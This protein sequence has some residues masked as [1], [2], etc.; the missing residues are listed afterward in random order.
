M[1]TIAASSSPIIDR[2]REIDRLDRLADLLDGRWRIP[3]IGVRFGID[4]VIGLIPGIG[5]TL[6]LAVSGWLVWRAHLLGVRSS[7]ILRMVANVGIDWLAGSVPLIG[8]LF[9]VAWK[10]N[11]RNLVLLRAELRS[12]PPDA[13]G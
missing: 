9:D 12:A 5:D 10:A 11:Q 7:V 13:R 1:A 4:S 2:E 8:D 6:T 3:G